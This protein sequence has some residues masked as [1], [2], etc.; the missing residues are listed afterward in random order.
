MKT[1]AII[2][3][4]N[5]FHKGHAAHLDMIR[6]AYGD[7]AAIIAIMSGNYT[8]RG[9]LAAA[10]AFVRAKAAVR[11]GIQLVLKLPFPFSA[12]SAEHFAMAGVSIAEDL[13]VTDVLSFGSECGDL[14]QLSR[15]AQNL[16][17]PIF[18]AHMCEHVDTRDASLGHARKAELLYRK[19]FCDTDAPLLSSP[20]NTLA[21]EY[22]RALQSIGSRIEPHTVTREGSY[23]ENEL[24]PNAY[25]SATAIRNSWRAAAYEEGFAHLP[26][27]SADVFRQELTSGAFPVDQNELSTVVLAHFRN[28]LASSATT[29][30]AEDGCGLYARLCRLS[31]KATDLQNLI[32][33]SKT[34]KYTTARIRRLI[35][36][37]LFGVTSS[38]L[39]AKPKYTQLLA[40]DDKGAKLLRR[41]HRH[42]NIDVLTK[43]ADYHRMSEEAVLQAEMDI[44][45]DQ[46]FLLAR[47]V[48]LRND[49]PF[50][51]TPYRM[52]DK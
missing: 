28:I 6:K 11:S 14:T 41:I 42:G 46:L 52:K 33:I 44:R 40:M 35:W 15:V 17:S 30:P 36:Y 18:K 10:D 7:D 2:S 45:A 9:D 37:A 5:P 8:Q 29:L 48:A 32:E 1:V 21:I 22:L 26:E 24:L 25:P 34:K 4:Y 23:H 12:S 19:L 51:R 43:P 20:N 39:C 3:E 31:H 49:S 16:S 50:L 47:N 38:D 27:A 13:G